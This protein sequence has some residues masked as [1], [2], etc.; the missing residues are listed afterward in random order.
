MA[1]S[2]RFDEVVSGV[3][4]SVAFIDDER[5]LD[6]FVAEPLVPDEVIGPHR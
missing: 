1:F 6:V 5:V 3:V 2:S 4:G